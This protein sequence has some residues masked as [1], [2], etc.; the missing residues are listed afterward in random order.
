LSIVQLIHIYFYIHPKINEIKNLIEN[1]SY[2]TSVW[3]TGHE[4][5]IF[6]AWWYI[7]A[8]LSIINCSIKFAIR[9][10]IAPSRISLIKRERE[11]FKSKIKSWN[12]TQYI[13]ILVYDYFDQNLKCIGKVYIMEYFEL[14]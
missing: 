3:N 12:H 11:R 1:I 7:S 5:A 9:Q 2:H 8:V 4:Y 14:D 10:A 6:L 13:L